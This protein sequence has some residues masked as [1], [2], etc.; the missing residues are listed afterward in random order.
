MIRSYKGKYVN[1]QI[2]YKNNGWNLAQIKEFKSKNELTKR[3]EAFFNSLNAIIDYKL[4]YQED[5]KDHYKDES[6]YYKMGI[7]KIEEGKLGNR[8]KEEKINY[9]SFEITFEKFKK[10]N[11]SFLKDYEF[12][13]IEHSY[14]QIQEYYSLEK[15]KKKSDAEILSIVDSYKQNKK[16]ITEQ[17]KEYKIL[18]E[19]YYQRKKNNKIIKGNELASND[20]LNPVQ[21]IMG[22]QEKIGKYEIENPQKKS[23]KVEN[24][25]KEKNEEEEIRDPK[26]I[27]LTINEIIAIINEVTNR[28]CHYYLNDTQILSLLNFIFKK[29]DKGRI[30][31]IKTGE[32]KTRIIVSLAS[33][34]V[35]LGHKVDIVTSS[36]VLAKRD[37]EDKTNKDIYSRLGITVG[38][39]IDD[40]EDTND[41]KYGK[42]NNN[43][44]LFQSGKSC[45]IDKVDVIYGDTHHFQADYL[46]DNYLMQ[47]TRNNREFDV[48]IVDEIDSMFI[49]EYAKS[50]LLASDK[51]YMDKLNI[52]LIFMWMIFPKNLS[53][54]KII[55]DRDNIKKKLVEIVDNVLTGDIAN[56]YKFQF[57]D[58]L[59]EYAKIEKERWADNCINAFLM[60][61]NVGYKVENY[62]E[63]KNENERKKK[64]RIVPIDN[65]NTGVILKNTTLSY[66]LHQFLQLKHD[67]PL[68]P[69]NLI[70]SYLSNFGFFKLYNDNEKKI[71]KIYGLTGTLGTERCQEL[72]NHIYNLDF[73]FIPTARDRFNI[74]L[75]PILDL[76]EENWKQSI[77]E[78]C[79]REANANRV[80]L[81][82]CESIKD[83]DIIRCKFSQN[84][85][86]KKIKIYQD[87]K[88]ENNLLN[89][90]SGSIVIATN[91]AGRGTDIKLDPEIIKK[92]GLH[93]CLTFLPKN[94]RVEQQAFGRA[95]RKGE[96]GT[97]QLVINLSKD[98]TF[99]YNTDLTA[100]IELFDLDSKIN[101]EYFKGN[102]NENQKIGFKYRVLKEK[103][104]K[105]ENENENKN[106]KEDEDEYEYKI[107]EILYKN[108]LEERTNFLA[109]QIKE[110]PYFFERINNSR[111]NDENQELGR[112]EKEID[113]ITLKDDLFLEYIKK[114]KELDVSKEKDEYQFNDLEE[115]WGFFLNNEVEK[116]EKE[117]EKKKNENK[118]EEEKGEKKSENKIIQQQI[119]IQDPEKFKEER[120]KKLKVLTKKLDENFKN[121][122]QMRNSG[123][124]C[125]KIQN[126]LEQFIYDL[127][128]SNSLEKLIIKL[129][130]AK[131]ILKDEDKKNIED[132]LKLDIGGE[133]PNNYSFIPYYYSA[134]YYLFIR[135][136]DNIGKAK[137][138]LLKSERLILNEMQS[139]EQ[140]IYSLYSENR[141]DNIANAFDET[142]NF[143]ENIY[144]SIISKSI[145]SIEKVEKEKGA[146]T[147]KIQKNYLDEFFN[148]TIDEFVGQMKLKGFFIIFP[149]YESMTYKKCFSLLGSSM[150][151]MIKGIF[152]G[153]KELIYDGI[154]DL[155]QSFKGMF[156]DTHLHKFGKA[157]ENMGLLEKLKNKFF[158]D[159]YVKRE[160]YEN[161]V[162]RGEGK[163]KFDLEK[164]KIII[165]QKDSEEIKAFIESIKVLK[166]DV[167]FMN[168]EDIEKNKSILKQKLKIIINN[169]LKNNKI[170]KNYK[171]AIFLLKKFGENSE[172]FYKAKNKFNSIINNAISELDIDLFL[173]D[174]Y[175]QLFENENDKYTEKILPILEEKLFNKIF[176]NLIETFEGIKKA[177]NV[178]IYKTVYNDFISKS[179][180]SLETLNKEIKDKKAKRKNLESE[181]E[182]LQ[183]NIK[184]LIEK[185]EELEKKIN[186]I[187]EN[188]SKSNNKDESI[189]NELNSKIEEYNKMANE[190]NQMSEELKEKVENYNKMN[191]EIQ[192]MV[193]DYNNNVKKFKKVVSD[194]DSERENINNNNQ[195]NNNNTQAEGNNN[196]NTQAEGNNNNNTQ[197]E[198]NNNNTQAE[199]NNNNQ[200]VETNNNNEGNTITDDNQIGSNTEE[201]INGNRN[202]YNN[203][204][205]NINKT[206]EDALNETDNIESEDASNINQNNE[207]NNEN[208]GQNCNNI[209]NNVDNNNENQT[210]NNNNDIREDSPITE[211]N[212][213][214]NEQLNRNNNNES[215]INNNNSIQNQT[216][217]EGNVEEYRNIDNN[218]ENQSRINN[219]NNQNQAGNDSIAEESR[220]SENHI[221]NQTQLDTD[222]NDQNPDVNSDIIQKPTNNEPNIDKENN[223]QNTIGNN[224]ISE[225]SESIENHI[226]N[227]S[228]IN[229]N[230][231]NN[232]NPVDNDNL[233]QQ[234]SNDQQIIVD[235]QSINDNNNQNEIGNNNIEQGPNNNENH[236]ENDLSTNNTNNQNQ[237]GNNNI[238]QES[239]NNEQNIDAQQLNDSN[240]NNTQ[241]G[242]DSITEESRNN[243]E[244]QPQLTINDNSQN[245]GDNNIEQGGEN[246][247]NHNDNNNNIISNDNNISQNPDQEGNNYIAQTQENP[248]NNVEIEQ[249]NN[250]NNNLTNNNNNSN[251]IN[252]IL[253]NDNDDDNNNN[254]NGDINNNNQ[255]NENNLKLSEDTLSRLE[256]EDHNISDET[257]YNIV[258]G[259]SNSPIIQQSNRLINDTLSSLSTEADLEFEVEN[260]ISESLGDLLCNKYLEKRQNFINN[261]LTKLNEDFQQKKGNPAV[262]S[263]SSNYVFDTADVTTLGNHITKKINYIKYFGNIE[264]LNLDN[265][266][267][268]I[269][270]IYQSLNGN[271]L[272]WSIYCI[273][274]D[275]K[276]ILYKNSI[277][278]KIDNRFKTI[279]EQKGITSDYVIKENIK[280]ENDENNKINNSGIIC[281]KIIQ[282]FLKELKNN[283]MDD[284]ISGFELSLEFP[285]NI[286]IKRLRKDYSKL[287]CES[288]LLKLIKSKKEEEIN[289]EF[290]ENLPIIMFILISRDLNKNDN[291]VNFGSLLYKDHI[292]DVI[293]DYIKD[294]YIDDKELRDNILQKIEDGKEELNE[295]IQKLSEENNKDD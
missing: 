225:M 145:A 293:T 241:T 90:E 202:G 51:P 290:W 36:E 21:E 24:P 244:S 181:I 270:G 160:Y 174:E 61:E 30:A 196:S 173:E 283:R 89:L 72:L 275:K 152:G 260:K 94:T 84:N 168:K 227:Q 14:G 204:N 132:L 254:A 228:Q 110:F 158:G 131:N 13:M 208:S 10:D 224:N 126:I 118:K 127:E 95:G 267:N 250:N 32:G 203:E 258:N 263:Y 101:S 262:N 143:Y 15:F 31:E 128:K 136:K 7:E 117:E 179:K 163:N 288:F 233:I 172:I 278:K 78:T 248:E 47:K 16:K 111:N 200:N 69:M 266:K 77:F 216:G 187:K 17:L 177:I 5:F 188:I 183:E 218:I 190:I 46:K 64:K 120:E 201:T 213:N 62:E 130:N 70:T 27:Y 162:G 214:E 34:H 105:K 65:E 178:K 104:E 206:A 93:V 169:N 57:P 81:I 41:K 68:T 294:N 53:K 243:N 60:E 150:V 8:I 230:N 3:D 18:W 148:K 253:N 292:I 212:T 235:R 26:E 247:E 82:I 63:K 83:V 180:N 239:N 226:E 237:I 52:F 159:K 74:E 256:I 272:E 48:I 42:K 236:N 220:N 252:N 79:K 199:E 80:V 195:N 4:P 92:G 107:K 102:F 210:G 222:N 146:Y 167:H 138:N 223:N 246:N 171:D 6:Y 232:Q 28:V 186:E 255:S 44:N 19:K 123:F 191:E 86:N 115:K 154:N 161:L 176:K 215:N 285:G 125:K 73:V 165:K 284:F 103:K 185:L 22:F 276:T 88:D 97:Y 197:D 295:K 286:N 249:I 273:I 129:K 207:N 33:I 133:K 112:A 98:Y 39:C 106:K 139:L 219:N 113:K 279:L 137:E 175:K 75:Y 189:I 71:N 281:L 184:K 166:M 289:D 170:Y 35:I 144:E 50:T 40:N 151:K 240:N 229:N 9:N 268:I 274:K 114:L 156:S 58:Y 122:R 11:K 261:I 2:L 155:K 140:L 209:N 192:K 43:K 87:E 153:G 135:D 287:Y 109:E 59:I 271:L 269:L 99:K 141:F 67:C 251:D 245:Q 85:Y 291:N 37:A 54:N 12:E 142:H 257:V 234:T 264:N 231:N 149:F 100:L 38:H 259:P 56:H 147:I 23:K 221:G 25:P 211:N 121:N 49:D 1:W 119:Q 116:I 45:Y 124:I 265:D 193:D 194:Y 91:L 66:G 164:L 29:D 280:N 205:I 96:P 157:S 76:N 134:V 238:I 108:F 198:E 55:K 217:S 277:N 282:N 182:N 242:N 20:N